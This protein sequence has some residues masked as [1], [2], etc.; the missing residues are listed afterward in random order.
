MKSL[1]LSLVI[2]FFNEENNIEKLYKDIK[3][4]LGESI[5]YELIMVNNGS[6]DRTKEIIKNLRRRDSRVVL[7]D[8]K[9]NLGYGYGIT[10]GMNAAKGKIIGWIDGDNT[11]DSNYFYTLFKKMIDT[12]SV[13]GFSQRD[14]RGQSIVRRIESFIYNILL[15]TLFLKNF[16]DVNS[17]PKM[18]TRQLYKSFTLTSKDWFI[19]TEFCIN[20]YKRKV[21]T[22]K[23]HVKEK[24]REHG[25]SAVKI[26]TALEFLKNI[27]KY[28]FVNHI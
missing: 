2:P 26:T 16:Y 24:H 14:N 7:V 13:V 18:I 19:D 12:K 11:I 1:D 27:I 8:I 20:V 4:S 21:K 17:K 3:K 25:K 10:F 6:R 23:I 15:D 9:N 5:S 28:R 22:C